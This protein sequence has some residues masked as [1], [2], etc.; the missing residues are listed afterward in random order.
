[1]KKTGY[2]L[3]LLA[4]VIFLAGTGSARRSSISDTAAELYFVDSTMLRLI[5]TDYDTGRVSVQRACERVIAEL[6]KGRDENPKILRLI[7]NIKNGMSV[8]VKGET[9]VVNLSGELVKQ[10]SPLRQHELLTIYS[11]VNSLTSID[12]INTVEFTIDGEKTKDF[13]GFV[14]MRETFIPDYY[15]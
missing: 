14:D 15:I 7:P 2:V 10:H 12:G 9:A 8:R 3:A 6:I 11:I 1:M 5:P 13:K 4:A